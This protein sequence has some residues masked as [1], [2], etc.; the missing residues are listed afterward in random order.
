M[1]DIEIARSASG[2]PIS[3]I[4]AKLNI[5]D[6]ALIPYGTTKAKICPDHIASLK[7]KPDG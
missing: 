7:D 2:L 1:S 6:D 4:A 5:P 3:D